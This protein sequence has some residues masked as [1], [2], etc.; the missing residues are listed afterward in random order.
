MGYSPTQAKTS[1]RY[2]E[3]HK[4]LGLRTLCNGKAAK[5]KTKCQYH[6]DKIRVDT[7]RGRK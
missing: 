5:G 7:K 1:K 2:R 4:E 3:R 6:L